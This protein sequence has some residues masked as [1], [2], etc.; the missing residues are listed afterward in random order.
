M[1]MKSVHLA[2]LEP[3]VLTENMP[4]QQPFEGEPAAVVVFA[5]V[6][7]LAFLGMAVARQAAG[8]TVAAFRTAELEELSASLETVSADQEQ[9]FAVAVPETVSGAIVVP[10]VV[11]EQ[12]AV[13]TEGHFSAPFEPSSPPWSIL[14]SVQSGPLFHFD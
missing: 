8:A 14:P 12:A 5:V 7:P 1:E 9:N 2:A 10:G 13:S 6:A 11:A 4:D 3:F